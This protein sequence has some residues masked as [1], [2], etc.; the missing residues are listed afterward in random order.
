MPF[1]FAGVSPRLNAGA[2]A[3]IRLHLSLADGT[4]WVGKVFSYKKIHFS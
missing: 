1:A 4:K 3:G 2:K